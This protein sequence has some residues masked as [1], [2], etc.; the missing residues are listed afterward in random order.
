MKM[1]PTA[2]M[3]VLLGLPPFHVMIEAEAL[4]GIYRLMCNQ[5][6]KCK[7]TNFGHTKKSCDMEHE[8]NLMMVSD[9]VLLRYVFYKPF[10]V[11][12]PD[13]CEWQ[14]WFN[15]D[16]RRGLFW[17]TD[18]SKTHEGTDAGVY[19][20]GSRS[21]HSFS[22]GHHTMVCQAEIYAIKA[23]IME[24]LDKGYIGRNIYILSVRQPSRIL[25]VSK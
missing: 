22:L 6:W 5:Q 10:T 1:T 3:E 18:R 19:R 16:S 15:P 21:R 11:T 17:Y 7:P 13:K 12:F 23:C 20:W 8:L 2:T 25:R 14:N 9:R 4:A 24:N